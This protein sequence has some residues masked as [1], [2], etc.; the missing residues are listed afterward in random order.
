MKKRKEHARKYMIEIE[1]KDA[2]LE[3]QKQKQPEVL[4]H[5]IITKQDKHKC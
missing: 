5:K 2:I 1:L 4:N 3:T